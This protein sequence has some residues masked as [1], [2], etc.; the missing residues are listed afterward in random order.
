MRKICVVT[1]TRAEYGLLYWT[2][3]S[4]SDDPLLKLQVCV[5]GMHLASEFGLTYK[6]IES[7][8]FTIDEKVEILLSSDT[9]IGISKSIGLGIIS[10]AEVFQRLSP[11]VILILGDR[12]EIFAAASAAMVCKIPIAHC[13]G[14]ESTEGLIDESIRH[15]VTKMSHLHF[16]ASEEYRNRVIQLGEEPSR[17]FNVGALG[18]ENI[19]RLTLLDRKAFEESIGFN[20]GKKSIIVTFHPVTLENATSEK[21]F[22]ALL[23]AILYFEDLKIIFTKPNA[24][25][26]GRVIIQMIDS[27]VRAHPNKATAAIS[28]GQLKY[29]SSLQ[30]VDAVV[31][32][33]SSGLIE[34]PSFKKPTINIGDRQRGRMRAISVIDCEP[35]RNSIIKAI[36]TAF[37]TEFL[38]K[39]KEMKN[40]YGNGNSS[41][42]IIDQLKATNLDGIIKKRFYSINCR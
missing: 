26:D 23:D 25:T 5:T 30:F 37:S 35:E 42:M 3:K 29:L 13:H 41:T 28:L 17:V 4:I 32:N 40:P 18:I 1:G 6:E 34:V 19:N 12:F 33:S 22:Q 38:E 2:M 27:F 16:T 7:D 31:G 20:L 36:Q 11:D 21:Q 39:V 10:F 9:T 15:A 8:G 14:G 24:D